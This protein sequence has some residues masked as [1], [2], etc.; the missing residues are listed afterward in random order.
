VLGAYRTPLIEVRTRVFRS[1][2][3]LLMASHSDQASTVLLRLPLV[4][5]MVA[6]RYRLSLVPAPPAG[7]E[8]AVTLRPRAPC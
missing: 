5:A 2:P 1:R 8:A 7:V 4:A 3:S 6:E